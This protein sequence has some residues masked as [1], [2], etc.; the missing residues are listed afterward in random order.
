MFIVRTVLKVMMEC[1][2]EEDVV[3]QFNVILPDEE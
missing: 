2:K 3:K 1:M